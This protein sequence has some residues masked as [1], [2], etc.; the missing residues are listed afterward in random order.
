[1][2][3]LGWEKILWACYTTLIKWVDKG[4][5]LGVSFFSISAVIL[6]ISPSVDSYCTYERNRGVD[7]VF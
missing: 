1:M 7:T 5:V 6:L 4:I 2:Y 3:I